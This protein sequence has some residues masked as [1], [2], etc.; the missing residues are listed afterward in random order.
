VVGLRQ[1][2]QHSE[3]PPIPRFRISSAAAEAYSS[4]WQPLGSP[5]PMGARQC[6]LCRGALEQWRA[7]MLSSWAYLC[8]H[9]DTVCQCPRLCSASRADGQERCGLVSIHRP[10]PSVISHC[11]GLR[12]SMFAS[13]CRRVAAPFLAPSIIA[14]AISHALSICSPGARAGL[15]TEDARLLQWAAESSGQ[16]FITQHTPAQARRIKA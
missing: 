14:G 15:P 5:P 7:M 9:G 16:L 1:Q 2:R 8:G 3:R 13:S 11:P 4:F 10:A 12:Q 6:L